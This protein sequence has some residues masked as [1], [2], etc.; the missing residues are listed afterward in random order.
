MNKLDL[1]KRLYSPEML[2]KA[3]SS[4][5]KL[6]FGKP[7][8]EQKRPFMNAM[9]QG[10]M[11]DE[12]LS[13]L[14]NVEALK[15]DPFDFSD[16]PFKFKTEYLAEPFAERVDRGPTTFSIPL[17]WDAAAEN[18]ALQPVVKESKELFVPVPG[19]RKLI[20]D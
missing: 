2:S 20:I 6:P 13:F 15:V 14:V 16:D 18:E 4:E 11:A 10:S 9:I 8:F 1:I 3:L 17:A 12:M 19:Q 7:F 5:Y